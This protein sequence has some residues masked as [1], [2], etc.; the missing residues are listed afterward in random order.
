MLLFGRALIILLGGI[1]G[2]DSN[3][4]TDVYGIITASCFSE[5]I[6]IATDWHITSDF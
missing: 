1:L 3:R 5:L 6:I 4:C 2:Q